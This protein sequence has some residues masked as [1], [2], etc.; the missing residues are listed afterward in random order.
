M[1]LHHHAP[2]LDAE[3]IAAGR[4]YREAAEAFIAQARA[5]GA[6]R[7]ID[8]ILVVA[9]MWG[10]AVGLTKFAGQGALAFDAGTA[11]DME[12]ALWRAIAND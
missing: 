10:A 11:I 8:P 4:V 1:D 5:A 12:E 2:Y 9:L 3:S 7:D 6:I